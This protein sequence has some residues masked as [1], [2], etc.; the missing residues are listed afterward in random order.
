MRHGGARLVARLVVAALITAVPLAA[1]SDTCSHPHCTRS[2]S[3]WPE[4]PG[5]PLSWCARAK[6]CVDDCLLSDVSAGAVP[7]AFDLAGCAQL[8]VKALTLGGAVSLGYE[9]AAAIAA[10]LRNN[11]ALERMHLLSTGISIE[12]AVALAGA[13][14]SNDALYTLDLEYNP[15]QPEGVA[16]LARALVHN[17]RLTT[18]RIAYTE[19]GAEGAA[20]LGEAL[21]DH[22]SLRELKCARP[23]LLRALARPVACERSLRP[24]RAPRT[25]FLY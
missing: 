7:W 22:A 4:K 20:A 1:S 24:L 13:L 25:V 5:E 11:S 12:G 10:A 23:S 8:T 16:A 14:E 6:T 19:A 9:G 18:L 2:L 21:R 15:L 3:Y 17:R